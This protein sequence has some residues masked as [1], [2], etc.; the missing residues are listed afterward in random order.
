MQRSQ[1][2]MQN[3]DFM[4]LWGCVGGLSVLLRAWQCVCLCVC[5][6]ARTNLCV[7]VCGPVMLSPRPNVSPEGTWRRAVPTQSAFSWGARWHQ[8]SRGDWRCH[9]MYVN[10]WQMTGDMQTGE[11]SHGEKNPPLPSSPVHSSDARPWKKKAKQNSPAFSGDT[12]SCLS[13][14]THHAT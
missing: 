8:P 4:H 13:G 2:F 6:E 9:C 12:P 10:Q 11:T 3:L 7:C 5:K 14:V 1:R